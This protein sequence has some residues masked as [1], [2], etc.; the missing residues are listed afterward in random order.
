MNII[1]KPT[2]IM[3]S[4]KYYCYIIRSTNLNFINSTYNGS[5]NNLTRRLRQH[6][7]E[8]VGGAKATKG[9]GHWVYIAIWEGFKTHKEAL[10]CEWKI[11]HPT[12]ARIRPSQFNGVGGRIKSLNLLT[13]LDCWTGKSSGMESGLEYILYLEPDLIELIDLDKKKT[14]LKI[15][16]IYELVY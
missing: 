7:G 2:I 8:I 6:N 1:N 10:S 3:D 13:G 12:N 14:N 4:S 16:K 15:K 5:T 9:K 11:K